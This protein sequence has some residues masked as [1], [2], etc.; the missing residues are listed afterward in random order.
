MTAC[1]KLRTPCAILGADTR[2]IDTFA[3]EGVKLLNSAPEAQC[4][5]CRSALMTGRYSIRSGNHTVA[6][7]GEEGGLVAWEHMMGDALSAHGYATACLGQ[8]A[9]RGFRWAM[10][11]R[12]WVR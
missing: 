6:M 4:T 3:N 2:R 5:P 7:P 12:T 10:A 11:Y 1:W 8:V 9:Y